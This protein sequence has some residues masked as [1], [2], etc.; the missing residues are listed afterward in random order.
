MSVKGVIHRDLKPE[1]ILLGKDRVVKI[2]DF[3]CAK[4]VGEMDMSKVDNFSLDKGT[5]L[6]ASPEQL[7]NEK[8]SFKCDVWA[9][10]CIA[11]LLQFGYHPFLDSKPHNTLLH[12]KKQTEG[13]QIE[14]DSSTNPTVAKLISL[15]LIYEDQ[16]RASWREIWLSRVFAPKIT[17]I[18]RFV[19]YLKTVSLIASWITKE[20]WKIRKDF[21]IS[22]NSDEIFIYFIIKFQYTAIK[23][24]LKII[25]K[26]PNYRYL[27]DEAAFRD[28]E[29]NEE[30]FNDIKRAYLEYEKYFL[31]IKKA[32]ESKES[33]AEIAS[34]EPKRSSCFSDLE[35]SIR[36]AYKILTEVRG[37]V[38]S[39]QKKET[40]KVWIG[41]S[42]W[43]NFEAWFRF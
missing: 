11:Y 41:I 6:Y 38:E 24:A 9:A 39:Q 25:K 20:F 21:S 17:D 16:E 22:K 29:P 8:Y 32:M 14:L 5:F 18:R 15:C 35:K 40:S 37:L 42:Y 30:Q 28:Y 13:K 1:N 27:F 2:G 26:S 19:D 3:G 33:F 10:G 36:A 34:R 7:K 4:L 43:I 12:I 23:T 31:T